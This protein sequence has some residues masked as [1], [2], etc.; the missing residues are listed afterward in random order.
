MSPVANL[1]RIVLFVGLSAFPLHAAKVKIT[2]NSTNT[3]SGG[4]FKIHRNGASYWTPFGAHTFTPG[5]TATSSE[6]SGLNGYTV[7]VLRDQTGTQNDFWLAPTNGLAGS[8]GAVLEFTILAEPDVCSTNI[9]I[10]N[11]FL[12]G[13]V[14]AY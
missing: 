10:V 11:P 13:V 5:Y 1:L 6:S 14:L 12:S 3:Y 8:S 4:D 7:T 2:N 9:C